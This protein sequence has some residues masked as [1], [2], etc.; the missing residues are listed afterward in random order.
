MKLQLLHGDNEMQ[1]GGLKIKKANTNIHHHENYSTTSCGPID[2]ES[3]HEAA[4]RLRSTDLHCI[5]VAALDGRDKK[6]LHYHVLK[7]SYISLMCASYMAN[8]PYE[9]EARSPIFNQYERL[10][11]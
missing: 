4:G 6:S 10:K 3:D 8:H 2:S 5:N 1:I 9:I 11:D 7:N